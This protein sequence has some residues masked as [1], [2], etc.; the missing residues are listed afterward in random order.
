MKPPSPQVFR[1]NE[2]KLSFTDVDHELSGIV[3]H[4]TRVEKASRRAGVGRYVTRCTACESVIARGTRNHCR[5]WAHRHH[6]DP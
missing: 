4:N 1:L 6:D 5:Y 3:L 2:T